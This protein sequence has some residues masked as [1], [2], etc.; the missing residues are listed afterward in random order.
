MV[1]IV[2]WPLILLGDG[3]ELTQANLVAAEGS[4]QEGVHEIAAQELGEV[5]EGEAGK[6]NVVSQEWFTTKDDKNALQSQGETQSQL[7]CDS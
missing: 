3:T 1:P 7:I 2:I 5:P 4:I 6:G